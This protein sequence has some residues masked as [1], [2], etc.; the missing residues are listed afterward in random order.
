MAFTVTDL[1]VP[2]PI[3][4]CSVPK[5]IGRHLQLSTNMYRPTVVNEI[6]FLAP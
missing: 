2:V 1:V 4:I 3:R 5:T 6:Q